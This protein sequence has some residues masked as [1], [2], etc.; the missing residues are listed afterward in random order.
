MWIA[1]SSAVS[2]SYACSADNSF[3]LS[4]CQSPCMMHECHL[5]RGPTVKWNACMWCMCVL[6]KAGT[7]TPLCLLR[8]VLVC[9]FDQS[10]YCHGCDATLVRAMCIFYIVVRRPV[11]RCSSKF[12]LACGVVDAVV[13]VVHVPVDLKTLITWSAAS[14]SH[15]GFKLVAAGQHMCRLSFDMDATA[16]L[17]R[18]CP[19]PNL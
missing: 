18:A 1:A 7:D 4:K 9:C 8:S 17:F 2:G 3:G 13:D 16:Y 5:L 11:C 10:L 19:T 14:I 15:H 12:W 6:R